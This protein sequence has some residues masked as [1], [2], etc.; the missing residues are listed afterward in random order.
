MESSGLA[1]VGSV[2]FLDIGDYSKKWATD[3]LILKQSLNRTLAEALETVAARDRVMLDTGDNPL[4]AA[5]LPVQGD[6]DNVK[7]IRPR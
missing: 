7:Q 5:E 1:V 3:Q 6:W 4:L 2:L